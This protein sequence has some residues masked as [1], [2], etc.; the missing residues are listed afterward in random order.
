MKYFKMEEFACKCCGKIIMDSK[1][2]EILDSI[3]EEYGKPLKVTSGYRCPKHN[4]EVSSTGPNG[5]HTT[6]KAVDLQCSGTDAYK[7][8]EIAYKHGITGIGVRQSGLHPSR[9]MHFDIL[10]GATRPWIWTY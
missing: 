3:R 4:Q 7:L 10:E 2:L 1:F 6:G 5:P 8:T 9:F